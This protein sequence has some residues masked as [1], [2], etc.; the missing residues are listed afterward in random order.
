MHFVCTVKF[1]FVVLRFFFKSINIF[2]VEIEYCDILSVF[3]QSEAKLEPPEILKKAS[4]LPF[5]LNMTLGAIHK[6][7]PQQRGS[8]IGGAI[9][10]GPIRFGSDP[11]PAL[12]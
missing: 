8:G 12:T 10:F 7:R 4:E 1:R 6:G 9:T 3:Y 2:L 5:C 11:T